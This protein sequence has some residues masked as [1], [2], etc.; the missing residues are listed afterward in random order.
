MI[1]VLLLFLKVLPMGEFAINRPIY[2]SSVIIPALLF[3]AALLLVPSGAVAASAKTSDVSLR[4]TQ[5]LREGAG[6]HITCEIK[7]RAEK[8]IWLY[9]GNNRPG[10]LPYKAVVT[11]AEKKL[12]LGFRGAA[13]PGGTAPEDAPASRYKRLGAGKTIMF[14]ISL[15]SE[16]TDYDPVKGKGKGKIKSAD[17]DVL[18]IKAGYYAMALD[19]EPGCCM[20][21]RRSGEL[22]VSPGWE[23]FKL[24]ETVSV[25]VS[26]KNRWK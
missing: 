21:A 7:N 9:V 25:S 4:I 13:L 6:L 15:N 10:G 11:G 5:V 20:P 18:E 23:F 1:D 19:E 26:R 17:I 14:N 16:V 22:L 8:D 3:A 12:S 2:G 24:E